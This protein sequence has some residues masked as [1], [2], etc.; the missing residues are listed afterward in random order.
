M[1]ANNFV[2][3]TNMYILMV[4]HRRPSKFLVKIINLFAMAIPCIINILKRFLIMLI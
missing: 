1:I 3:D 2:S 4:K